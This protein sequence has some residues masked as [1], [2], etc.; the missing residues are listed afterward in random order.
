[1]LCLQNEQD[2]ESMDKKDHSH[3]PYLVIL[4]KYLQAW[5]KEHNGQPPQNYKEK[6]EFKELVR[7]T[8][9]LD[10][11][12]RFFIILSYFILGEEGNQSGSSDR[13]NRGGRE[14]RRSHTGKL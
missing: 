1:M 5:K 8:E 2:L 14:F 6:K 10:L 4:Y 7:T 12:E 3:T 11:R 9:W 13:S